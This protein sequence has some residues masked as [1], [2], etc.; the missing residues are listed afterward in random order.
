MGVRSRM[1]YSL[2]FD[3][4]AFGCAMIMKKFPLPTLV[5]LSGLA[6]IMYRAYDV[7]GQNL[8]LATLIGGGAGVALYHASFGFTAGW[9]RLVTEGRSAGIRAQFLLIGLTSLVSFPLIGWYGASGFVQPIGVGLIFGSFIFGMGMQLGGGCGSGTLFVVGGGSTRMVITLSCFILGS[10]VGVAHLP[11]W[12]ELP[13]MKAVSLIREFGPV[14]ALILSFALMAALALAATWW[15][16]R[17]YGALEPARKTGS[18]LKGP[19]SPWLGAIAL[20]GIGIATF[21]VLNRPWGIT[22]A[23]GLWGAKTFYALGVPVDHWTLE[24][25]SQGSLNRSV[26]ASST[27]VMNFGIILGAMAAAG[28][29]AR[30]K[31]VFNLSFTDIWTAVIGGLLMGYGARLGYGC[32]I[33]AYLGGLVSGSLHG[34]VWGIAAFAGSSLVSRLRMPPVPRL[35][36][37]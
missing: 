24:R 32:N 37:A 29:A 28:M 8:A 10:V 30:W 13:R 31:P 12:N 4:T 36:T 33:G 14:P 16:R 1:C 2:V 3:R 19:W 17:K 11:W 9:R 25:W 35:S 7:S 15:E 26:F 20:A 22:S 34:W 27:S 5:A 18:L 6:W 23:F 21:L